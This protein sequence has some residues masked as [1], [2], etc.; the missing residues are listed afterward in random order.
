MDL[1]RPV[2]GKAGAVLGA[3]GEG[4]DALRL[5]GRGQAIQLAGTGRGHGLF[6]QLGG[7]GAVGALL[8]GLDH[9]A[10]RHDPAVGVND[11]PAPELADRPR[12]D[13]R[14]RP[15]AAAHRRRRADTH[16]DH[17]DGGL[18]AEDRR[19]KLRLDHGFGSGRS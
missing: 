4:A 5:R 19:L 9:V 7:E 3:R 15:I 8:V 14:G 16:H 13:D 17:D 2:E 10:I 6:E 1:E 11:G 12:L 18:G